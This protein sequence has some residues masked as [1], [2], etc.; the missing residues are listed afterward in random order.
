MQCITKAVNKLCGEVIFEQ[1]GEFYKE[2]PNFD[3]K[4]FC[5]RFCEIS[6]KTY[7]CVPSFAEVAKWQT[8]HLE[9]VAPSLA[10]GFKSRLPHI[11]WLQSL[12][13]AFLFSF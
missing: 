4:G 3:E 12:I 6:E 5:E 9:G 8:H 2:Y 7:L 11:K 1:I 13:G 10:Y